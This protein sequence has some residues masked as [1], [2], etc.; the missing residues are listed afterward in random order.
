MARGRKWWQYHHR[1]VRFA[2][3]ETFNGRVLDA[4][5]AYDPSKEGEVLMNL[6]SEGYKER[7]RLVV[8]QLIGP[9]FSTEAEWSHVC[10]FVV[11]NGI[12]EIE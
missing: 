1:T 8:T 4:F 2:Q 10:T 7:V 11:R 3:V 12:W 6:A 5:V 9:T